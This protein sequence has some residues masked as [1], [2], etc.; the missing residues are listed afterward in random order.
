MLAL[1]LGDDRISTI[2]RRHD[3]I[4]NLKTLPGAIPRN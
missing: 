3:I 2:Q 4:D 1:Y